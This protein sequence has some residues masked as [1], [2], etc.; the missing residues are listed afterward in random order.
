MGRHTL[1]QERLKE[2]LDYDTETGLFTRKISLTGSV[3]EGDIA[4]SIMNT[5]YIEVSVDGQR[6]LGHR[7]AFLFMEGSVPKYVD[8]VNGDRADNSWSNLRACTRSQNMFNCTVRKHS[9]TGIKNVGLHKKSGLY[10]V[11]IKI[12]GVVKSFG[13]YKDIEL[14]ELVAEEARDKYLG[15]FNVD[16]R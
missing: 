11:R 14:A 13:Y 12:K 3:K 5:G 6:W 7:L 2:L 8:H 15:E 16:F 1:T 4:G 9:S 10:N